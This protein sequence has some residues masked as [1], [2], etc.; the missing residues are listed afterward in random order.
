VPVS[1]NRVVFE[2]IE[3]P[4]G[5]NLNFH[6]QGQ[7]PFGQPPPGAHM[8]GGTQVTGGLDRLVG[9]VKTFTV[10]SIGLAAIVFGLQAAMPE[11][12]RPSDVFG[13]FNGSLDSAEIKA[14]QDATVE[15]D[16]RRAEA[17][18]APSANLQ[19]EQALNQAQLQ[20]QLRA[21]EA[22]EQA[23][24]IADLACMG[25]GLVTPF[26]GDTRD[27]REWRDLLKQGCHTAD[28]IRVRINEILA[29]TAREGSGV[30]QRSNPTIGA[31]Q[32]RPS[33]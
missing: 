33:R 3:M 31:G 9:L 7:Q 2:E 12:H 8:P 18:A 21:L 24:Q 17:Q 22:Q 11:G 1:F 30:V 28:A 10:S 6:P 32:V 20:A 4:D 27:A 29:A 26:F 5:S 19:M 16:R 13:S 25:A 23:A 15:F 14:K